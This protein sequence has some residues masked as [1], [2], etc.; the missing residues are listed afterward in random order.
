MGTE[1]RMGKGVYAISSPSHI[2]ASVPRD[3][4]SHRRSVLGMAGPKSRDGAL[5]G[6]MELQHCGVQPEG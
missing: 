6:K 2:T 3:H 5:H 4:Q 1:D